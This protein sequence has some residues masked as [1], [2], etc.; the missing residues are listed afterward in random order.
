MFDPCAECGHFETLVHSCPGPIVSDI[1]ALVFMRGIE[2]NS[3]ELV[4]TDPP[5][6]GIVGDGWDNQWSSVEAYGAWLCTVLSEVKRV[7][8]PNGSALI[9][10]CVG[11]HGHHPIFD[12]ITSAERLGLFYRNWLTW[13]KRRGYGKSHD[14]IFVREEILWFSKSHERTEVIFDKPYTDIVRGYK[15]F[16]EKYPAHSD[17]KRVGNVFVDDFDYDDPI[18]V[19]G[20]L[21]K[22]ERTAQK[23]P[24]LIERL[25]KAHSRPKDRIID[26]FVGWGS[27]GIGAIENDR[28]FAGSEAIAKDAYDANKR[29]IDARLRALG[30][31]NL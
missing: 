21:M 23:P 20:E 12:L 6:Y 18:I 19:E 13:R 22:P 7:L 28:L 1:D 24:K 31:A 26:P 29:C 25:V 3:V 16:N 11:K 9:F 5:F 8:T 14:Y 2:S 15:G 10:H 4:L 17:F 30:R 27:T